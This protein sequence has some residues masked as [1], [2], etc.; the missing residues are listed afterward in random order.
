MYNTML[1]GARV[2]VVLMRGGGVDEAAGRVGVES[3]RESCRGYPLVT[4]T[5]S[6]FTIQRNN[7]RDC[8]SLA[9]LTKCWP[10][11]FKIVCLILIVAK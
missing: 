8:F 11:A 9:T 2:M 1:G 7:M 6:K 4:S 3:A 5:I 10:I